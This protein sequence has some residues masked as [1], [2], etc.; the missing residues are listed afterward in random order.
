MS[1]YEMTQAQWLHFAG[2]NPSFYPPG[3]RSG[4][5]PCTLLNPVE[6]VTWTDCMQVLSRLDLELPTEAQWEYG[7]RAGTTSIWWTGDEKESLQGAAN[8]ADSYCRQNGGP[9]NWRYDDWLDDGWTLHARVGSFRANA[10]GLHDVIGNVWEWCRDGYGGYE[11]PVHPGDGERQVVDLSGR[12]LRGGAF[13]DIASLAR[14]GD[15]G[16]NPPS[17][18][19]G[20]L[21]LRPARGITEK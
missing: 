3:A 21:G 15:R 16:E 13:I 12:A 19:N 14:S 4:E 11:L 5:N 2:R 17:G 6:Q 1:K 10:F 18:R 8:L 9:S 20:R 7:A